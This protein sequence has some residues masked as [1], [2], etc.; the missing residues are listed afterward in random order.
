MKTITIFCTV[1]LL[2]ACGAPH[3]ARVRCDERLRPI[4][5]P[6]NVTPRPADAAESTSETP[7]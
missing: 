7:P 2:S 1:L 3:A 5:P 6:A 4:N